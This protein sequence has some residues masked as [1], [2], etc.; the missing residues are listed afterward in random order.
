MKFQCYIQS[1]CAISPQ[2]TFQQDIFSEALQTT[3]T[4]MLQA[5]Q[6]S[7]A[8]LIPPNSL[9]R[10]S[11]ALKMG[12]AAASQCLAEGGIA[13]PG[14]IITGTGKGSLQDMEKFIKD[15]QTYHETALNPTQFIQSTF[16]AVNGLIALQQQNTQYN[17]TFVHRGLSFES[18]LLDALLQLSAGK[19]HVLLGGFDEVTP[20]QFQIKSHSGWWKQEKIHSAALLQHLSPGTIA[21]EGAVFFLLANQPGDHPA[22]SIEGMKLLHKPSSHKLDTA[23]QQFLDEHALQPGHIDLLMS[24]RNGDS[25]YQHFYDQVAQALPGIPEVSF[26]PLCGEYDT[27]HAFG[28]WLAAQM[29]KAGKAPQQ[30]FP[31]GTVFPKAYRTVLLYNQYYGEQHAFILLKKAL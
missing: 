5:W 27:A 29:I 12:L 20:D 31:A 4:N 28:L 10:M 8:G 1:S 14:A 24:G 26:K 30:W 16:N 7:Y 3:D 6:P 9:R 25:N 22:A 19:H 18:A 2:H 15:I 13:N 21:G 17:N 11:K 23:L